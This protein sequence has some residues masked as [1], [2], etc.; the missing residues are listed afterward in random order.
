MQYSIHT[1]I[2]C[3]ILGAVIAIAFGL[4]QI[5]KVINNDAIKCVDG[6]PVI[7]MY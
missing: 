5:H 6:E 3:I 2:L 7:D 4:G 1:T